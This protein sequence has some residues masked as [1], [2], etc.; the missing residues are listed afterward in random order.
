VTTIVSPRST[1]RASSVRRFF[2]S[3]MVTVFMA[4]AL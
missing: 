1:S 4:Q 3:R 2:A